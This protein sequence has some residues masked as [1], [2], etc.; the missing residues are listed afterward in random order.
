MARMCV[1]SHYAPFSYSLS[2]MLLDGGSFQ[3]F[4]GLSSLLA[5]ESECKWTDNNV[6][7]E[8]LMALQTFISLKPHR[9]PLLPPRIDKNTKFN[10][11]SINKTHPQFSTK[12]KFITQYGL[13]V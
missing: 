9:L 11:I 6:L 3:R 2:R 7:T 10:S 1:S 8:E 5:P 13:V 4:C 12:E